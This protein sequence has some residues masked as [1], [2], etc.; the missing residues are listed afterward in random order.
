MHN[1]AVADKPV[2]SRNRTSEVVLR[3]LQENTGSHICDSGGAYGRHWQRNAE[4]TR[5]HFEAAPKASIHFGVEKAKDGRQTLALWD[6][7]V[8]L[9]HWMIDN[10]KYDQEIQGQFLDFSRGKDMYDLQAME[11]FA[12]E[13][14]P[15]PNAEVSPINTYNYTDDFDLSQTLQWM[16]LYESKGE[17]YP[18]ALLLQVHGGATFEAATQARRR[19]S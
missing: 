6:R 7:N 15:G 18:F 10:L 16:P 5:K 14:Y 3:M 19:S 4:K 1:D 11:E 8:S 17:Y 13:H 9:Y 12:C 2:R